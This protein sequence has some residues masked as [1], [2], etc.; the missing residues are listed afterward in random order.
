MVLLPTL[1]GGSYSQ[2]YAFFEKALDQKLSQKGQSY[3][4]LNTASAGQHCMHEL[5]SDIKEI[6]NE[7]IDNIVKNDRRHKRK[8]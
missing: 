4:L 7:R 2:D 1:F 5:V 6:L 8:R 3:W